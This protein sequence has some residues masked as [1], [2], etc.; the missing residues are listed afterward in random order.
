MRGN[1]WLE[2]ERR[3]RKEALIKKARGSANSR[4]TFFSKWGEKEVVSE[5]PRRNGLVLFGPL[6]IKYLIGSLRFGT[7]NELKPDRGCNCR[8]SL[9]DAFPGDGVRSRSF[10][11]A[12]EAWADCRD[13]GEE[14][15][16]ISM[17]LEWISWES[18][19]WLAEVRPTVQSDH[20]RSMPQ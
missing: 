11:G 8:C 18:R 19:P 4:P 12:K 16:R 14:D 15:L 20:A 7:P 10:G 3:R 6:R 5:A 1:C 9:D 2:M 13:P 17:L